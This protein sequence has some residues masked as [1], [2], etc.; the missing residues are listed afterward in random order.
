M[1]FNRKKV[2]ACFQMNL[3]NH[4][5]KSLKGK[6]NVVLNIWINLVHSLHDTKDKPTQNKRTTPKTLK[7]AAKKSTKNVSLLYHN[8]RF[9]RKQKNCYLAPVGLYQQ[10]WLLWRWSAA[11]N[12]N[13]FCSL[14]RYDTITKQQQQPKPK[15]Q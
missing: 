12:N 4:K 5:I 2:R 14:S 3:L 1:Q 8:K 13:S 6:Q 9:K 15:W 10:N 7:N 11:N